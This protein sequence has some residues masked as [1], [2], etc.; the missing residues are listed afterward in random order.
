MTARKKGLGRGL[1][2]LLGGPKIEASNERLRTIPLH[3]LMPGST[4]RERILIRFACRSWLI[5][6]A[7]KGLFS[8]SWCVRW[9]ESDMK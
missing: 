8:Q 3:M 6:L 2:A 4:S 9:L 1:D 7:P 5:R